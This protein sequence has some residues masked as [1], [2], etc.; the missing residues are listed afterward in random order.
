M[1]PAVKTKTILLALL[2]GSGMSVLSE[3][4][5]AADSTDGASLAWTSNDP[6]VVEARQLLSRGELKKADA[7]L[8][9]DKS[10]AAAEMG[11]MIRRLRRE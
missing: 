11:E 1:I 10:D 5:R 9:D 2:V 4:V 6:R 3:M 8:V 7:L